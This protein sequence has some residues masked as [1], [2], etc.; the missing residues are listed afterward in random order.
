M[1][2]QIEAI[3]YYWNAIKMTK[4]P[5]ETFAKNENINMKLLLDND[6]IIMC[7]DQ[8][9][10]VCLMCDEFSDKQYTIKNNSETILSMCNTCICKLCQIDDNKNKIKNQFI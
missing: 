6:P 9:Y 4:L 2:E 10:S 1:T 5:I 3:E 8:S 7:M